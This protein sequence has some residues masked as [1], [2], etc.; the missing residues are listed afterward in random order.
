V[1]PE[2]WRQVE[3]VYQ[4]A[5]EQEPSRRLGLV[6]QACAGDESLQRAVESLLTHDT[7]AESFLETRVLEMAARHL[8]RG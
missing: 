5:L 8:A 6:Q 2:R 1:D 7:G 4:A 3:R